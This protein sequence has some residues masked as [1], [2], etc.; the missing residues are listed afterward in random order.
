MKNSILW[1][2][3]LLAMHNPLLAQQEQEDFSVKGKLMFSIGTTIKS[4]RYLQGR[5]ELYKE[6]ALDY[7]LGNFISAGIFVI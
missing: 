1:I 2:T 6:L 5:N 4:N 3:L 7:G